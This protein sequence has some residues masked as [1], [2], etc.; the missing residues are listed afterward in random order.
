MADHN[1]DRKFQERQSLATMFQTL[2]R[3]WIQIQFALRNR[4][5]IRRFQGFQGFQGFQFG[6][7]LR[8][9]WRRITPWWTRSLLIGI[10]SGLLAAVTALW[11]PTIAAPLGIFNLSPNLQ[12]LNPPIGSP[13]REIDDLEYRPIAIDGQPTSITITAL[14]APAKADS[15]DLRPVERRARSI[16]ADIETILK[17][18][19]S[20]DSFAITIDQI[21]NQ[22]VLIAADEVELSPRVVLTV[23]DTDARLARQPA[24]QLAQT[25]QTELQTSFLVAQKARQPE[26]Q[27]RR[28]WIAIGVGLTTLAIGVSLYKLSSLIDRYEDRLKEAPTSPLPGQMEEATLHTSPKQ[29]RQFYRLLSNL[30]TIGEAMVWLGGAVIVLSQFAATRQIARWLLGFP[31]QLALIVLG[32]RLLNRIADVFISRSLVVWADQQVLTDSAEKRA[33][34]RISTLSTAL[35]GLVRLLMATIGLVVFLSLQPFSPGSVLAGAG[36]FGAALAVV[37]Q[38]LIKDFTTGLLILW[39]DQF[40]VGDVI[41]VGITFGVVESVGLRVT[42]IRGNGGRLSV[43]PNNQI[44][45][46][47][48]LTKDWS[49]VDFRVRIGLEHDTTE[50]MQLMRN[51]ST[52]M[53]ADPEWRDRI[54]NPVMLIGVDKLDDHGVEILQWI[55]TVPLSQWDVEREYRR[56]LK[57]AFEQV[58]ITIALPQIDLRSGGTET[59]PASHQS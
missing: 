25:W 21:A 38:N 39:E 52:A 23:T 37:F 27:R 3:I 44:A 42:K 31:L 48:N 40:A 24:S 28:R 49:R 13:V 36:V 15:L 22:P 58:G 19:F 9:R 4:Q 50:A 35:S 1:I 41:D 54:L 59:T 7:Q 6:G 12:G 8:K 11:S 18:G 29:R 56:R 14:R 46:V 32:V 45:Y 2:S 10:L 16:E 53:Q 51:V 20:R 34:Q 57:S 5:R 33:S 55:Q 26:A 47:H 30:V 43:V 17:L